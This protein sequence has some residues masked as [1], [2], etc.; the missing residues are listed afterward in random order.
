MR[1]AAIKA[2]EEDVD[3]AHVGMRHFRAAL[4]IAPPSAPASAAQARMYAAFRQ[5][6]Q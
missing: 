5:G 6:L 3:S 1:E 4:Q 2:L